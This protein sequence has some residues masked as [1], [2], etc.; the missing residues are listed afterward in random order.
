MHP[1]PQPCLSSQPQG[2]SYLL[3]ISLRT[4]EVSAAPVRSPSCTDHGASSY[5]CAS[6]FVSALRSP[7]CGTVSAKQGPRRGWYLITHRCPPHP[8]TCISQEILVTF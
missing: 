5:G 7:L 1:D 6:P 2:L 3:C 8:D 4:A